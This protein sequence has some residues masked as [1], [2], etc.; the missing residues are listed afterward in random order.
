MRHLVRDELRTAGVDQGPLPI[1]PD[2]FQERFRVA[3]FRVSPTLPTSGMLT[4]AG[5]RYIVH[6]KSAS[7]GRRNFTSFHELAHVYFVEAVDSVLPGLH[8]HERNEINSEEERLCNIAASEFLLPHDLFRNSTQDEQLTWPLIRRIASEFDASL[9]ATLR[10]LDE[11]YL[12]AALVTRWSHVEN[13]FREQ[14]IVATG[15][16]RQHRLR[17]PRVGAAPA[18]VIR[19]FEGA[20]ENAPSRLFVD[21]QYQTTNVETLRQ[22]QGEKASVVTLTT[23]PS[24]DSANA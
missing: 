19:A 9:E 3:E 4:E 15:S 24:R 16:L 20:Q 14:T 13:A 21:G 23:L 10:R 22:Q 2:L 11:L 12:G 8:R 5:G 6:V 18:Y 1:R 7:S 17:T